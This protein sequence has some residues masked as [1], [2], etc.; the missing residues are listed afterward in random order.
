MLLGRP[1]ALDPATLQQ[2]LV[3]DRRG[4][5][6]FEQNGL[7]LL[8][9]GALGFRVA[10]LSARMR[11]QRPRDFIPPRTHLFLRVEVG[12]ESWLVDSGVGGLS[13][14][15]AIRLHHEGAQATPHEPR[16]IVRAGALWFHQAL[17]GG[18]WL[19]VC[20][21]TLEEMP[22]IDRE[23]ANWWTSTNPES[24]FRQNLLVARAAPHGVRHALLNR[25]FTLRN[26]DGRS[27]K[28]L[29]ESPAELL[30][31]LAE[32]FGLH[33][34]CGHALRPAG[35]ALAVLNFLS[36]RLLARDCAASE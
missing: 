30:A 15:G 12:G 9:P 22:L 33:F 4:G 17:L 3:R 18:E 26:A 7:L 35:L 24:K 10:P 1:P 32:Y 11:L 5:Y 25:E 19:D 28:R 16:R 13:L 6:C 8:V 2:K 36:P 21:F 29:L 31:V 27:E 23:V 14:T 34:P 20:V